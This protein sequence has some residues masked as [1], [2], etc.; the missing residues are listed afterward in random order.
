MVAKTHS[1]NSD[2]GLKGF[3]QI[4]M[5]KSEFVLIKYRPFRTKYKQFINQLILSLKREF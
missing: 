1:F 2:I 3:A 5:K 4:K